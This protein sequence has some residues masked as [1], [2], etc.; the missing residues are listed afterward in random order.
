MVRS[1]TA[2]PSSRASSDTDALASDVRWIRLGGRVRSSPASSSTSRHRPGAS[3]RRSRTASGGGSSVR[4]TV[5]VPYS[6]A[7][8]AGMLPP[9]TRD[10][11]PVCEGFSTIAHS[12]KTT[13]AV[14]AARRA[15][16]T[17]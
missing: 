1:P 7:E 5:A 13:S 11:L 12:V 3:A 9:R 8:A 16:A 10:Q 17:T 15:N 6:R 2:K 4:L 14:S